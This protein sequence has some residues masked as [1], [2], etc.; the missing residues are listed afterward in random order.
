M[1]SH[2]TA[3]NAENAEILKKKR[4]RFSQKPKKHSSQR[5][6]RPLRCKMDDHL[7]S[8]D[9]ALMSKCNTFRHKRNACDQQC[10][11]FGN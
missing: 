11:A 2:F 7:N 10:H 6:L 9:L 8:Y 3:E 5:S 1:G 4:C